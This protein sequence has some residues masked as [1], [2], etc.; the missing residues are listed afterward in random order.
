MTLASDHSATA[1]TATAVSPKRSSSQPITGALNPYTNENAATNSP[2]CT[3]SSE[4][5]LSTDGCTD[6]SRLRSSA[7]SM[8]LN[9][10]VATAIQRRF[11]TAPQDS[12][13]LTIH[14]FETF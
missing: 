6:A 7:F 14:P 11:G 3:L 4:N 8:T 12:N 2:Y 13:P 10:N 1:N 5:C 9:A